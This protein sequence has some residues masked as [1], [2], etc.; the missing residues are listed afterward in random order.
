MLF[1]FL[2]LYSQAPQW[3]WAVRGG[4]LEYDIGCCTAVDELGNV[5]VAGEFAGTVSYGVTSFT[6]RGNV[7][8]MVGK[9]NSNHEWVW[10]RQAGGTSVDRVL[11]IATDDAGNVYV[12]GEFSETATFAT[13]EITSYGGR[14]IYVAK[15]NEGGFLQWVTQAGSTANDVGNA[16]AVN[17]SNYIYVTGSCS[18]NAS[19]SP[20]SLPG[21]GNTDIFVA[22]M[23]TGG[24]WLWTRG[25][26]GTG[27]DVG[28]AIAVD[29]YGNS[30]VTGFFFNTATFGTTNLT[31]NGDADMFIAKLNTMGGLT[32][33]FHAGGT[34]SDRGTGIALDIQGNI[35]ISG[36]YW[37][38]ITFGPYFLLNQGSEDF[39][40][41]KMNSGAIYQWARSAGGEDY[42]AG[43]AIA[44]DTNGNTYVTGYFSGT[45]TFAT[46]TLTSSG[47]TDAF[48]AKLDTNG[49]LGWVIQMGGDSADIGWSICT[50]NLGGIFV[51][52][53]F[54]NTAAFGSTILTSMGIDDTFLGKLIDTQVSN[55]DHVAFIDPL[56]SC[57]FPVYPN[58]IHSGLTATI[59][60]NIA[61]NENGILSIYNIRGQR[62]ADY[63]LNSGH[64]EITYDFTGL[65]SGVYFYKLQTES[66]NLISKMILIR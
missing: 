24:N 50:N 38:S 56:S 47:T 41:V 42:D 18:E 46:T 32:G 59:K 19:F 20:Y 28:Q 61:T 34:S 36:S 48:V 49:F 43:L 13:T 21:F 40:V 35:Y 45:A 31:S 29:N 58:P 2:S 30:F 14:D 64:H 4:G 6:S 51:T 52:G 65:A 1:S 54:L 5:Y 55:D 15:L 3:D 8:I 11:G 26:G 53:S 27:M 16:I 66:V 44:A 63:K 23:D 60:A 9:L 62:I 12:T 10:V 25:A 17:D 39:F 22:K 7:D 33:A 57:L 37:V